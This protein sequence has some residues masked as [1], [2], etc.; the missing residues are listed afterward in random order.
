MRD[1]SVLRVDD[2]RMSE[3]MSAALDKVYYKQYPDFERVFDKFRQVKGIDVIFT[4][5]GNKY[6]CDEK[7]S[8]RWRNLKTFSFEL[9]F[10]DRRGEVVDGWFI[11]N[12][13]TNNS[14]LLIWIDKEGENETIE[15]ALVKKDNILSYLENLGWTK[16]KLIDK[17]IQIRKND[18]EGINFGNIKRN[19]CKFSFSKKLPEKPINVL[20]PRDV[21]IN[22][23]DDVFKCD[24]SD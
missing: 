19:G 11:S 2:E 16:E 14:Y 23:A 22:L 10:I 5:N 7:A 18:G 15:V 24:I 8:V 6:M 12:R 1:K 4:R 9:S 13:C 3:K 17:D 21:L 20:V